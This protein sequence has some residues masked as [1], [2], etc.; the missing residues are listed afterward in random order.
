VSVF[1]GLFAWAVSASALAQGYKAFADTNV[2]PGLFDNSF[3]DSPGATASASSGFGAYTADA[4]AAPGFVLRASTKGTSQS[5]GH[6]NGAGALVLNDYRIRGNTLGRDVPLQLSFAVSGSLSAATSP[7]GGI[8]DATVSFFYETWGDGT[9]G[10]PQGQA[11]NAWIHSEFGV[12]TAGG[13]G[14]YFTSIAPTL[15]VSVSLWA[16]FLKIPLSPDAVERL[17]ADPTLASLIGTTLLPITDVG[18]GLKGP[19]KNITDRIL[20]V[21]APDL[22]PDLPLSV[23]AILGFEGAWR[24]EMTVRNEGVMRVG[25]DT[26]VFPYPGPSSASADFGSTIQLTSVTFAPGYDPTG[27]GPLSIEFSDG[28]TFAVTQ[29]P[30]PPP[31]AL[32]LFGLGSLVLVGSRAV[33]LRVAG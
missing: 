10:I 25:L 26:K 27:L 8:S 18:F 20:E 23:D 3:V 2:G 12:T 30:I 24:T 32:M 29:I 15:D 28:S 7:T 9:L 6:W 14:G 16:G 1:L 5:L 21:L 33:R 17:K 13:S 22:L 11:S 4:S 31:L 19:V